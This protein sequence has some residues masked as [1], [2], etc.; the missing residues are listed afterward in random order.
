M[1]R[2]ALEAQRLIG[3]IQPKVAAPDNFGPVEEPEGGRELQAVGCVGRIEHT[4]PEPD[5]R[6]HILLKG[7]SRFRCVREIPPQG[8]YRRFH[9]SYEAYTEDW[10]E[11]AHPLDATRILCAL[12]VLKESHSLCIEPGDFKSLTGI[13]VL[14]GLAAALPFAPAEKQA[15]LE[16]VSAEERER[17]LIALMAMGFQSEAASRLGQPP[18]I[19]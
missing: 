18:S 14:N 8:E 12:E 1:V 6:F 13:A 3:I 7:I 2:D 9:V 5:G 4:L 19:H 16:A 10:R 15:L 11:P 17:L